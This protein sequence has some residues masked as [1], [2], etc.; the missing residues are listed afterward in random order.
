MLRC[1]SEGHGV[2]IVFGVVNTKLFNIV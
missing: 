1:V 2:D